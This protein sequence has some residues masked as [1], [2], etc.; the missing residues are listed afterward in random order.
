[1]NVAFPLRMA[2]RE[3]R[4]AW[5]HFVVFLGC[6]ALGVAALVSVGTFAANLDRT[7][8]REARA[9]TGG[10]V[11][12]RSAHPLAA[13]A[14]G[15]LERLRDDGAITTT[16]RELVGMARDPVRGRTLLIELKAVEPAYPLYGQVH[17][18]PAIPLATLLARR[19]DADGAVVEAQL[20]E[21]MGLVVGDAFVVGS[22]RYLITGVLVREPDRSAG[23]VTLG[24]RVLVAN[25][26][27]ER[28]GLL[29]VGSR[30]R[31]RTLV[32]LAA[33]AP[34]R[35]VAADLARAV[36]DPSVRIA[37]FDDAQPGLRRF[38]S[39]LAT[40]LGLVGLAS[41][42]VG[43]VGIASSVTTFLR[44][45]LAT[46]AILK[47]LGAGW[48]ALLTAYLVQTQ[49]VGLLGSLVGA[50]L[51]VAIQPVLVRALAPFA[52]FPLEAQWDPWT[53]AR[54]IALG[55][56]TA[57]LCA[58]WP[59]LAVRRVPP[60]LILRRDVDAGAWRARRPWAAALP[61]AAGLAALAIWQAGSFRLG[62]IF[63]G[64]GAAAI[65]VLLGLSRV[66]VVAT[67]RMPRVRGLAWRQGLA[68]LD[69]P[70]GHTVRVVVA[71]GIGAM[72]LVAIALL[73]ANLGRQI[74]Y[75][76][77]REAPAFFFIDVQPDQREGFSRLLSG[78]AGQPP[79]LIPVVRARLSAINGVP[80]TR[81]LIDRRKFESPDK[82]W[83]LIREYML[84]WAG[85]PAAPS[86]LVRGRWWTP[87]EAVARPRVSVE[88]E[89]AKFF[90]VDVG[91]R[92][93]FDI[94]GVT[95]EAEVMSLRKVDWQSLSAN[96]FM[97]LS[98]GALDG[99]PTTYIATARVDA[100][101]E[102][103]MQNQVVSAFPNVT[104]I[105][106][107]AVLE[108]VGR[109]LDQIS[110]AVRF[111]ALFS[112]AAGLVVMTGALAATRYQRLYESV[113]FK[114]LGATRWAIARA[115]AVEYAC[116]GAAAGVGGTLLAAIL[117]WIV[118]RFVLDAPWALEPETL[119]LG[120]V[121]TTGV[122]LA[123][124]LLATVRLLGRKPLAVLRQE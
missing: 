74:A 17:T 19:D 75:E 32:R 6:V 7:L 76:Q 59:L 13:D 60:S 66:L 34:L 95:V 123:V 5:R 119:V 24:P 122:S 89:A 79:A 10:D 20:L 52:P 115:F 54:G 121:L 73:E 117:A 98:P 96:F 44:R 35:S 72:L 49:A 12:L 55:V 110:F 107:R 46:I 100:A 108:R 2:W 3:T 104:A 111:M 78:A 85:E 47:C 124:G 33:A 106:V 30:V 86:T 101:A 26:S 50:A 4:G 87:A 120:V 41:L 45:Q 14:L 105:P 48:R 36:G 102:A 83:Y 63:V 77:K 31:T 93:T 94:Q 22:A 58:L 28:T 97:I 37:A 69:R 8:A 82:V 39:Q 109:V 9:L 23:L 16:V 113:I 29:Q 99:A 70:G 61:I 18:T 53:I 90:G 68:G 15:A 27:L 81:E 56:L 64:A 91:G 103:E 57:L 92:L 11:E 88:D 116:L 80:L 38:F 71:L 84:T 112:I 1:V 118:V 25:E 62:A 65:G 21:R 43:G 42:L 114:T 67:R 40:Y 51:G